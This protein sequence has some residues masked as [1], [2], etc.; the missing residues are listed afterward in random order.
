MIIQKEGKASQSVIIQY[1]N[2]REHEDK[3]DEEIL[4]SLAFTVYTG[5]YLSPAD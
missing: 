5:A 1:I 2:A 4:G 3:E